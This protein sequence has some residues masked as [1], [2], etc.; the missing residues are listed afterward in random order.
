MGGC[1]SLAWLMQLCIWIVIVVAI[2]RIFA[3]VLPWLTAQIGIPFIVSVIQIVIWAVI[4]I[5][6]IYVIFMLLSCL[7]GA[8]GGLLHFPV[9]R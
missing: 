9:S 6:C 3:L 5:M 8:G 2:W 7:L 1:F 4:A